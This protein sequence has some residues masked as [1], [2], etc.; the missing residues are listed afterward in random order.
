MNLY[1]DPRMYTNNQAS[2]LENKGGS[3]DNSQLK[4]TCLEFEAVML[5]AM[6]KAMR[7][8]GSTDG[9]LEK[10]MASDVYRDLFDG[11]VAREMAHKQSLGI[12]QQIYRQLQHD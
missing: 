6:F 3:Q 8:S 2:S 4:Q 10:D 11:E 5:Q 1:V 9:L 7:G 12:G